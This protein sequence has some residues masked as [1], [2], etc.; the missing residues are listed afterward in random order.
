MGSKYAC[1]YHP[2]AKTETVRLPDR[3][4]LVICP[5]CGIIAREKED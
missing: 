4:I 5:I 3:S 2:E 1:P